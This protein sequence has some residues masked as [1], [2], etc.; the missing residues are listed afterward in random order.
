MEHL[1]ILLEDQSGATLVSLLLERLKNADPSAYTFTYRIHHYKGLGKKPTKQ[2]ATSP[3]KRILLDQLPR[4][5]R[6]YGKSLSANQAV[7]VVVDS[8]SSD[9]AELNRQMTSIL[10]G[11]DPKPHAIFCI[12]IEEMEAW[13]LGD[14]HAVLAAYPKARKD[15]LERYRQDSICETWELLAD[16]ICPERIIGL[17]RMGYPVIGRRKSEWARRIGALID[18]EHNASPSFNHFLRQIKGLTDEG[19]QK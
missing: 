18:M 7:V 15:V 10:N 16:A 8:D 12:A 14:K 5:L 1:E 6:G 9:C 17:K 13:L 19:N 2:S 3:D 11:C 4:L